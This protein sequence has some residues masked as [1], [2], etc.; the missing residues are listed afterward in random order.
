[1]KDKTLAAKIQRAYLT[2]NNKLD[3]HR[4]N[5]PKQ[6]IE[7]NIKET[8]LKDEFACKKQKIDNIL[9]IRVTSSIHFGFI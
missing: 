5:T 8:E 7:Q 4:Y 2:K 1:M 6:K 9:Y 3:I